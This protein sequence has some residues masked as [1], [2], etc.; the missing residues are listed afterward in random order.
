MTKPLDD[1]V[2]AARRLP[3]ATQDDIA[4]VVLRLAGTV[5]APPVPLSP[6]ERAAIAKSKAAAS[7]GEFTSDEQVHAVWARHGL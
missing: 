6:G 4:R 5:D 7:G 1:A 2:K 3:R